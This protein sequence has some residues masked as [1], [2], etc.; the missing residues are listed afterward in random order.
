MSVEYLHLLCPGSLCRR[1]QGW[2]LTPVTPVVLTG[3]E[4]KP[5]QPKPGSPYKGGVSSGKMGDQGV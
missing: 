1:Y 2:E 3:M 4:W 5:A